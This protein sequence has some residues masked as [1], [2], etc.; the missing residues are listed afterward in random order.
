MKKGIPNQASTAPTLAFVGE[1]I[2]EKEKLDA[3][4]T[5]TASGL[6]FKLRG[7]GAGA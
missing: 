6:D 1:K 7:W 2:I 5:S 3:G 4:L